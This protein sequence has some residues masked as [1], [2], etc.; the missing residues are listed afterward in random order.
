MVDKLKEEIGVK[1]YIFFFVFNK[2]E[3]VVF[4]DK[5]GVMCAKDIIMKIY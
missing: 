1:I 5:D 4:G 2:D 3:I